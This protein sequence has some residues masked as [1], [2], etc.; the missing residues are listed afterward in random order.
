MNIRVFFRHLFLVIFLYSSSSY[1]GPI[2][3]LIALLMAGGGAVAVSTAATT[4]VAAGAAIGAAA[5]GV[6]AIE[7]AAKD[8]AAIDRRHQ[9]A[10]VDGNAQLLRINA[11]L[12]ERLEKLKDKGPAAHAEC[13]HRERILMDELRALE[14]GRA[15]TRQ[16]L[17]ILQRG[18]Y[19]ERL[20][21]REVEQDRDHAQ[22]EKTQLQN[23]LLQTLVRSNNLQKSATHHRNGNYAL[24]ALL[25]AG[26]TAALYKR[27]ASVRKKKAQEV[28]IAD[29]PD[30]PPNRDTRYLTSS[31]A[32]LSPNPP[33]ALAL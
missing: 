14:A 3:P 21:R 29:Q 2:A 8:A 23:E 19:Q 9:K 31:S 7:R 12:T 4:G 5:S 16:A 24:G 10:L 33:N 32:N 27:G 18:L 15:N 20:Q 28:E 25:C 1:S 11:V 6:H 30:N 13:E 26:A 22:E 17:Q